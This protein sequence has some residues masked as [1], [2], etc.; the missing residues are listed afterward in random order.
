MSAAAPA[1]QTTTGEKFL[2]WFP[3]HDFFSLDLR[4]LA[5]FR[6]GLGIMLL[7][8]WL[9]R[10]TDLRLHYSDDGMLPRSAFSGQ[11]IPISIFMLSGSPW[12]VGALMAVGCVFALLLIAGWRTQFVTFISW[13]L[14]IGIHGRNFAIMQ[15]G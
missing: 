8:E 7:Q 4:S 2:S 12:Y 5:L 3:V 6:I 11:G 9:N 1:S 13:F 10:F 14:L 15:G